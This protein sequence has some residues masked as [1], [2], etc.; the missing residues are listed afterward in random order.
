M[1]RTGFTLV[2][3]LVALVVFSL[4]A[5]GLAA[6]TA[7]LTRQLGAGH[8]AA[9]VTAAA[10]TRLEGLRTGACESRVAGL[11]T[12]RY[13]SAGLADLEWSWRDSGD[14][15]YRLTLTT[16]PVGPWTP[17]LP[18]TLTTVVWCRR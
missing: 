9:I 11:E 2:E 1:A 5:L 16:V 6:E 4:G 17:V 14:S 13:H 8:R 15:V 18:D 7:A 10:T 12:V 3:V